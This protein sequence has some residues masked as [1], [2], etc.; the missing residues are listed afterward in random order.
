M[1]KALKDK[2]ARIEELKANFRVSATQAP[3]S[4]NSTSTEET[5]V[6]DG[7]LQQEIEKREKVEAKNKKLLEQIENLEKQM[8]D[9]QGA[10]P[11]TTTIV[12]DGS[13]AQNSQETKNY[14]EKNS[15]LLKQISELQLEGGQKEQFMKMLRKRCKKLLLE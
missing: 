2:D 13:G 4:E 15:E 11:D 6:E 12:E 9:N 5:V 7:Q 10:R 8:V 3:S 1:E 14:K